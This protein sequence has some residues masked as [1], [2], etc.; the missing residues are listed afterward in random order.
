MSWQQIGSTILGESNSDHL[1]HKVAISGDGSVVAISAPDNDGN[2]GD[3]GEVYVYKNNSGSWTKI[4]EWL[5]E[6]S[7]DKLGESISLSDDGTVIA[8]GACLNDGNGSNS[9]HVRV[10]KYKC[11]GKKSDPLFLEK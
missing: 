3:S 1:G 5:G 4:G 2:G 7:G 10:F 8:F 9:G 11:L 6:G